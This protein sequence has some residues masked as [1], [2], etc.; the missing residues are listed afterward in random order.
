MI[1]ERVVHSRFGAGVVVAFAPPRIEVRFDGEGDV[2][3]TFAYPQSVERF[4]TLG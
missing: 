3:R 2:S 4:L 1:G